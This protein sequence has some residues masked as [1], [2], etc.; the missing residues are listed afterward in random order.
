[1]AVFLDG[2]EAVRVMLALLR[3]AAY[4]FS[5]FSLTSKSLPPG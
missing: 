5:F 1:V 4:R 3:P 2:A